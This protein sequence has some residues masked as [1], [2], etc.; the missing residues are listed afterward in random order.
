MLEITQTIVALA[1]QTVTFLV[2]YWIHSTLFILLG[3]VGLKLNWIKVDS[4]GETLLKSS[5]LLGLISAFWVNFRPVDVITTW[6]LST[7]PSGYE[8]TLFQLPD[9]NEEQKSVALPMLQV[10][11]EQAIAPE[12]ASS[13]QQ[14]IIAQSSANQFTNNRLASASIWLVLYWLCGVM[15]MGA[16]RLYQ[17][18]Q[19]KQ[20]MLHKV[21]LQ[22]V[23]LLSGLASL[24]TAANFTGDISLFSSNL[25][26]SPI[27]LNQKEIV[28]PD[29]FIT[30]Y[31]SQQQQA[32]LAHEL[33]H[34]KRNDLLWQ[35]VFILL[36]ILFFFQPL[37]RLLRKNL[38]QIVEHRADLMASE[39]TG[40]PRAL[41]EALSVAAQ[42]QLGNRHSR[43]VLAMK[44][45]KSNVLLRVECLLKSG[46]EKTRTVVIS[47]MLL[48]SLTL[49]L[50]APGVSLKVS[51]MTAN[52]NQS[53]GD[54]VR[55]AQHADTYLDNETQVWSYS[56]M[57][58]ENGP[59][60]LSLSSI[61]DDQYWKLTAD[62][63]WIPTF[64]DAET[65]IIDFP[66]RSELDVKINDGKHER[67]LT[68]TRDQEE[69]EYRYYVNRKRI[70]VA[71][72]QSWF[73]E[74]IPQ[75][76]R[77]TGWHAKQR[78]AR[79]LDTG[80]VDAVLSEI[81]LMTGDEVKSRYLLLLPQMHSL[82]PESIDQIIVISGGIH[83]D[84]SKA[85]VLLSLLQNSELQ[86]R[87]WRNLIANLADLESDVEMA[88][89]IRAT[90][91]SLPMDAQNW[92]DML[93]VTEH[94]QSDYQLAQLLLDLVEHR[95]LEEQSILALL[96]A[97]HTIQSDHQL[98]KLLVS[99]AQT[100]P[101]SN[102]AALAFI[103]ATLDLQSDF[104][105]RKSL[106]VLIQN[107]LED[108]ALLTIIDVAKT[109]IQSDHEL[110]SFFLDFIR[111][112]KMSSKV[113]DEVYDS[114]D[115]IESDSERL[116]VLRLLKS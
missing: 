75:L 33:A 105:M 79:L 50:M 47:V 61:N 64:N 85:V 63:Q 23:M 15:V 8:N 25:L 93:K 58:E 111:G 2:N 80:S 28:L 55:T 14:S 27:V 17:Y 54:P 18:Y 114:L 19:L 59:L 103:D 12:T 53:E 86:Q 7:E 42:Q 102:N 37:N 3:F 109:H 71:D 21:P 1:Y 76:L 48:V 72:A 110:A 82:T 84:Y 39:W 107:E 32:A 113:K 89:V 116:K 88:K 81:R 24:K 73:S 9:T 57:E 112:R 22:D 74:F 16:I 46:I 38:N 96:D 95:T 11:P 104:E 13:V 106:G 97:A 77:N 78:I 92:P 44:C 31:S 68:I 115:A 49:V 66:P 45:E 43:W 51:A 26:H 29:V 52:T 20:L 67:R 94:I 100:L 87:N 83:S 5:L 30:Q 10:Q 91:L 34:I 60:Q 90:G 108:G 6:H 101:L 99:V 62:L 65:E 4:R 35:K 98:S 56:A 36:D 70:D 41:A 69:P 40:N